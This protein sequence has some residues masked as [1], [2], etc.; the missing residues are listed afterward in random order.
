MFECTG[1]IVI[2]YSSGE[3]TRGLGYEIDVITTR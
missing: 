1:D 3:D 2:L